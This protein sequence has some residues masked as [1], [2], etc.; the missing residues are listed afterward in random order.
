MES[1]RNRPQFDIEEKRHILQKL[2]QAVV[3]ENFLHTKYVGQ[4][5]FSLQ[6]GETLIPGLDA[7]IEKGYEP[8]AL[9]L[10]FLGRLD[11]HHVGNRRR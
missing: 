4:K 8:M 9:R 1:S 2:N 7:I 3:F 11:D 10:L 6:G 5:R